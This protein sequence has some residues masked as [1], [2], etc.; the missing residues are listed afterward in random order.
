M[1]NM[2]NWPEPGSCYRSNGCDDLRRLR[3]PN[4]APVEHIAL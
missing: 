4:Y 3:T 2:K 1:K